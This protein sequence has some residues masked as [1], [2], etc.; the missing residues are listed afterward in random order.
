MCLLVINHTQLISIK[1]Q[2]GDTVVVNGGVAAAVDE[3]VT[4]DA[5]DVSTISI[6]TMNTISER[7]MG[8]SG[9]S[10]G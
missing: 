3:V 2:P 6:Y 10:G 4:A 5:V 9:G 7:G 1:Y 8:G